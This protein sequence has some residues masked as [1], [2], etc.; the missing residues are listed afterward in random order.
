[1]AFWLAGLA[2]D[3]SAR[4]AAKWGGV[5]CMVEAARMT[6]ANLVLAI[7]NGGD[8]F[9]AIV[10]FIGA[11][12]IPLFFAL[13]GTRLWQGLGM[14]AGTIAALILPLDF[15][16]FGLPHLDLYHPLSANVSTV[17]GLVPRAII[18]VVI[19]NG[20]RGTLALH[21]RASRSKE[22]GSTALP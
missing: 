3:A 8:T 10:W 12:V 14:I 17:I 4:R 5:A 6:I 15:A 18:C 11:S 20:V 16:L 13:T 19:L 2:N 22:S 21:S 7:M 9:L 1:M